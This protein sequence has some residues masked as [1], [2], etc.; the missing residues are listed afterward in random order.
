ME[1]APPNYATLLYYI[2]I[3]LT[4]DGLI[5]DGWRDDARRWRLIDETRDGFDERSGFE[6]RRNR[7][8]NDEIWFIRVTRFSSSDPEIDGSDLIDPPMDL[9]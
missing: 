5:D 1:P 4:E 8:Q 9:A 2:A 6:P 7:I 3:R